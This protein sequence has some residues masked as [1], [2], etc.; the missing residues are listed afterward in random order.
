MSYGHPCW[1][2]LWRE[3]CSSFRSSVAGGARLPC[4]PALATLCPLDLNLASSVWPERLAFLESFLASS[5]HCGAWSWPCRLCAFA[6]RIYLSFSPIAFPLSFG[7]LDLLVARTYT[8]I[9]IGRDQC[10][11]HVIRRHAYDEFEKGGRQVGG[12]S[13]QL[14]QLRQA[15][16]G[17]PAVR[18]VSPGGVLQPTVPEGALEQ[19]GTQTA[20]HTGAY[21]GCIRAARG[22]PRSSAASFG[23]ASPGPCPRTRTRVCTRSRGSR[24]PV[25][26]LL[27]QRGPLR[28]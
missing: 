11:H 5:R 16:W 4:V 17:C 25:P 7:L 3:S 19:R 1:F 22:R 23:S 26:D 2:V 12:R 13:Q 24:A 14:R 8:V 9:S 21:S 28:V 6:A 18:A 10:R 27:G 15:S 20:L